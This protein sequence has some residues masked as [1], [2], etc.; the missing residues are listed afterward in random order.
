M[1]ATEKDT[2]TLI[3]LRTPITNMECLP[4]SLAGREFLLSPLPA[5]SKS[6]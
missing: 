2:S 5:A 3:I 6:V 1:G 4:P